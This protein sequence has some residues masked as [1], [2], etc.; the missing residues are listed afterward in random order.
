[1]LAGHR[2]NYEKLRTLRPGAFDAGLVKCPDRAFVNKVVCDIRDGIRIGYDG[3]DQSRVCV[4]WPSVQKFS[5]EVRASI[6]RDVQLGRKLVFSCPPTW[7]YIA[8]PLG[9]FQK[10]SS[11][12]GRVVHD[13]SWPRVGSGQSIN[14]CISSEDYTVQY[15]SMDDLVKAVKQCGHKALLA[16]A[17]L[18]DAYHHVLVHPSDWHLLGSVYEDHGRMFYCVSTVLPFGLKSAPKL[19]TDIAKAAK[20]VMLYKGASFVEHYLDDYVT[21]GPAHSSLCAAN[22]KV[23]LDTFSELG[24]TVNPK[25]VCSSRTEL[26]FLGMVIDS[27]RMELLIS[28]ERL[29]AVMEELKQWK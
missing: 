26:E 5:G 25:K 17:D 27:N 13:L 18:S 21:I 28:Q 12:K 11:N 19:F 1:M 23:M 22:M 4:N 10:C 6:E 24:F 3:P 8:S 29:D 20:L 9:A 16:K 15:M 14:A 2:V 7:N